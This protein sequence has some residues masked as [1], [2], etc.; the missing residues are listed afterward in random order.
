[1]VRLIAALFLT[2]GMLAGTL[3]EPPSSFKATFCPECWKFLGDPGDLDAQ[4]RCLVS[5]K[6]PVPVEAVTV[7][8]FW[9]RPHQAWHRRPCDRDFSDAVESTALLVPEGSERVSVRAYCPGDRMMSDLGHAGLKCPVCARPFVGASMVE[10]RWFWCSTEKAWL[11]R[12]CPMSARASCCAPRSG[13]I[14]AHSWRVP[15]LGEVSSVVPV[16]QEMRVTPEWLSAHLDD[17]HLAV[18]QIGHDLT[19][20]GA[21]GRPTYFD[22]HI[23]GARSVAWEEIAVTRQGIPNEMPSAETLTQMVRSLGIDVDDRIVLYDS[24]FGLEAAR[25]YLTLDY[26]GLGDRAAILDG[27]WARWKALGYPQSRMPE[28]VEPSAFLPRLRPELLV[29]LQAMRDLSWLAQ[30][31]EPSVAL[32]DARSAEEF[33]GWKAGPGI[34]KPGHIA[35]AANL[36]WTVTFESMAD[37]QL[38]SDEELWA[39]FLA[40]GAFSSRTVIVYCRTGIE[41]SHLYFLAKYL[42]FAARF[43]DGSYYEW[44]REED[45]PLRGD[46]ARR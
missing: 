21:A 14:L 17:P 29:S 13:L 44:S 27:Q 6:K 42:G 33:S 19:V 41:A 25:A 45:A 22:G 28:E 3:P 30:Q 24:G 9:C 4:G 2:A 20:P 18:L 32:L 46:W 37:V 8:W 40:A 38:R 15:Y 34:F 31:P 16:R 12:P 10:R 26:L 5:G 7:A 35:G 43:Y 39:I 23:P 36:C 11:P 1:M